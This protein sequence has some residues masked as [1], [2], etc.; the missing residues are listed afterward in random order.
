MSLTSKQAKERGRK[1]GLARSKRKAETSRANGRLSKNGGRPAI[2]DEFSDLP[3]SRQA[4][5]QRRLR[6]QT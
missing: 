3:I 1:G 5:H 6:K 2:Q 4:K